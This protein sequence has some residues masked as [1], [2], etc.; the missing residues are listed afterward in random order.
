MGREA[1]GDELS[2][3]NST[4][5]EFAKI[6]IQNSFYLS[7][8]FFADSILHVEILRGIFRINIYRAGIV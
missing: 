7:S 1:T 6:P 3:G 2:K 5:G 4:L 8:F